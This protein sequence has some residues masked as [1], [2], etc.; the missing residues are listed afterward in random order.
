MRIVRIIL[1]SQCL[2][3]F[4]MCVIILKQILELELEF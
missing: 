2:L 1:L 3:N 4:L